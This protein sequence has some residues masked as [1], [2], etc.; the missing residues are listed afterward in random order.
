LLSAWRYQWFTVGKN[1]TLA[2]LAARN[3]SVA[4]TSPFLTSARTSRHDRVRDRR[5]GRWRAAAPS[6][7]AIGRPPCEVLVQA[8]R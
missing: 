7:Y 2:E 8:D 6:L 4:T 3:G 1:G 5:P